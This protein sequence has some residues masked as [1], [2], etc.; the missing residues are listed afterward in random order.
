MH[1]P[2]LKALIAVIAASVLAL[3][4]ASASAGGAHHAHHAATMT[5]ARTLEADG[6]QFLGQ[7]A[8]GNIKPDPALKQSWIDD[9]TAV[10][11]SLGLSARAL[12]QQLSAHRSLAQIAASRGVPTS[13]PRNV[14]LQHLRDNLHRAEQDKALSPAAANS[15]L[16]AL[17]TALGSA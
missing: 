14:L 5:N 10:A 13:I 9:A 7:L 16:D 17:G 2:L 11:H 6:L 4:V 15:L 3:G 12:A 8:A 1:L